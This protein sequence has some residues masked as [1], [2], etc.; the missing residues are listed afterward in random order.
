M[1][2]AFDRY[3][4]SSSRGWTRHSESFGLTSGLLHTVQAQTF[5][6]I[7]GVRVLLLPRQFER[8]NWP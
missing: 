7:D 5:R 8:G 3:A 4:R 2:Y 6:L 1:V